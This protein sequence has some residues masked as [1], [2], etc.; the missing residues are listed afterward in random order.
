[1]ATG[2][3]DKPIFKP[4]LLWTNS[5]PTQTFAEQ[6]LNGTGGYPYYLIL[7]KI[8][9]S[10]STDYQQLVRTITTEMNA[11]FFGY[12]PVNEM[13]YIGVRSFTKISDGRLHFYN[14][15]KKLTNSTS[16]TEDNSLL[17]PYQIY[18]LD[19]PV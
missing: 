8:S 1:M 12:T 4:I 9:T 14:A 3:I 5:D 7:Y 18:G 2:K 17:I 6:D 10:S 11:V 13:S 15:T 16:R 19:W